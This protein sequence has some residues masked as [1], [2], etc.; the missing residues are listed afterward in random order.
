MSDNNP[1][2]IPTDREI[3][4]AVHC[5]YEALRVAPTDFV[6]SHDE[7]PARE[8][9]DT[10]EVSSINE[11][12]NFTEQVHLLLEYVHPDYELSEDELRKVGEYLSG[13]EAARATLEELNADTTE[14]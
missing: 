4:G 2:E 11:M 3:D 8:V 13:Y 9:D 1:E 14:Y 7:L 10:V 5:L 12:I 6:E